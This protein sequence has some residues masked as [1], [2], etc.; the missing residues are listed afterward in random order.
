[1]GLKILITLNGLTVNDVNNECYVVLQQEIFNM[2][3]MWVKLGSFLDLQGTGST[4]SLAATLVLT[5]RFYV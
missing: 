2:K 5:L 3:I 1:M 4:S